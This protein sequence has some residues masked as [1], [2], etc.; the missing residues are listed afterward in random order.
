MKGY[1]ERLTSIRAFKS[2][3][4]MGLKGLHREVCQKQVGGDIPWL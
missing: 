4:M 1:Q 2:E 3:Q